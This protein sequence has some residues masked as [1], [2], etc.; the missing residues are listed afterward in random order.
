MGRR[1]HNWIEDYSDGTDAGLGCVGCGHG[2]GGCDV[3]RMEW[4]SITGLGSLCR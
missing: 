3:G 1:M 4:V 2:M